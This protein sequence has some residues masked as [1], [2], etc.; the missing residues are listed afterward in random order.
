MKNITKYSVAVIQWKCRFQ[1]LSIIYLAFINNRTALLA[2]VDKYGVPISQW[3][4]L[5]Q[6]LLEVSINKIAL[7]LNAVPMIGR[8]KC[9]QLLVMRRSYKQ[10]KQTNIP[11]IYLLEVHTCCSYPADYRGHI[12]KKNKYSL[13]AGPV[14]KPVLHTF[15]LLSRSFA[16]GIFPCTQFRFSAHLFI[17]PRGTDGYFQISNSE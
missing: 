12:Y 17:N 5:H 8:S 11:G 14:F 13:F 9:R 16:A 1:P 7:C 6:A 4:W 10:T 15:W 2:I 3:T